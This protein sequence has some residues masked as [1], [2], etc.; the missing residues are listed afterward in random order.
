MNIF[1]K[2]TLK[3]CPLMCMHIYA[4][5][6]ITELAEGSFCLE[7]AYRNLILGAWLSAQ[8]IYT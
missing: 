2:K 6:L 7:V 8:I 3:Q 4:R 5:N 1:H